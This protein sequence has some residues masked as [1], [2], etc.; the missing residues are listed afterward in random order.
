MEEGEGRR[1]E[2][3]E[4]VEKDSERER[5]REREKETEFVMT[6]SSLPSIQ[7]L[8]GDPGEDPQVHACKLLEVLLLQCHGRIDIVSHVA[9]T[10]TN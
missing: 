5:E 8:S 7:V 2:R 1:K 3:R 10:L 9:C 6:C 4:G